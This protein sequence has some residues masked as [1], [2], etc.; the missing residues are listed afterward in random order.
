MKNIFKYGSGVLVAASLLVSC[1]KD[2]DRFP[3]NDVTSATLYSTEA[4][5]KQVLA[6]VYGSMALTGNQGPAGSG[7]VAGI[8]EGTS[9]FLRLYWKAQ[10]LSTDEA[11]VSWNDVGIQDFHNM[12]WSANNPMLNGLYNRAFY[13]ITLANE[14]VRESSPEKVASRGLSASAASI[15]SMRA[16]A[17]FVR[18]YQYWMLMDLFANPGF[19]DENTPIGASSLPNQIQ[20]AALFTYIESELKAIADGT[21][22]DVLAAAKANEYGRADKAAAWSLLAR[23]Y[24]NAEVYTGTTK[25]NEAITYSKKVID[26]GYALLA[27]YKYLM[28]ADN[29]VGNTEAIWTLNYDGVKTRNY[30]GTTFLVNAATN[31]DNTTHKDSC[32]LT[33]WSGTR[34]TKNLPMLF[35]GYPNFAVITDKR[36]EFFTQGQNPEITDISKFT[37]GLAVTKYRNKTRGGSYGKDPGRTFSDIDFPVF[38]LAEMYL[39]FAEAVTRGGTT[40]TN[41]QAVTYFNLLRQRAYGDNSGN[42]GSLNLDLILDERGRELYWEGFRRSDLIRFN[43]FTDATYL[44]PWKGGV[45]TGT[46]VP[47]YRRIYPIPAT[48]VGANPKIHQNPNY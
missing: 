38:R 20:R 10:E 48:E 25:W 8:D 12:N 5:Y 9:D 13:V 34:T 24:L 17:R 14:F 11:V 43:K 3:P 45:S 6:K 1:H 32:G 23:M 27:N 2:L 29:N 39:I 47:S 37:D 21:T 19:V 36:A 30:G 41:A 16:E 28:L 18:A 15:S 33:G 22:G 40:G 46:G 35:P 26:A 42:V 44:W 7:D 31:G 4:G